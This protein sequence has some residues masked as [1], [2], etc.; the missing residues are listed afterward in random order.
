MA[1]AWL[2]WSWAETETEEDVLEPEPDTSRRNHERL[3]HSDYVSVVQESGTKERIYHRVSQMKSSSPPQSPRP[4]ADTPSQTPTTTPQTPLPSIIDLET[5][6]ADL[7]DS[8]PTPT[9]LT[10]S[11][12]SAS[13]SSAQPLLTAPSPAASPS[14]T[15]SSRPKSMPPNSI[16]LSD[17]T[18]PR[19]PRAV[20]PADSP[21]PQRPSSQPPSPPATPRSRSRPAEF[22]DRPPSEPHTPRSDVKRFTFEGYPE[23]IPEKDTLKKR[24]SRASMEIPKLSNLSS[25]A[26]GEIHNSSDDLLSSTPGRKSRKERLSPKRGES[27][28]SSPHSPREKSVKFDSPKVSPKTILSMRRGIK[29]SPRF[30]PLHQSSDS[31]T[32]V[33]RIIK[34]LQSKVFQLPL[35][36]LLG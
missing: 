16:T 2:G 6:T 18:T 12:L 27:D 15:H 5:A 35:T 23:P 25:L 28:S 26:P 1:D 20:E 21:R 13:P 4:T 24:S 10:V 36:L 11:P 29:K 22:G 30:G 17:T 7:P 34:N 31:D 9:S 19:T 14:A 3:K 32:E 8:Q 33:V